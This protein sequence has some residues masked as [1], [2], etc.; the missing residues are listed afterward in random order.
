MVPGDEYPWIA[1]LRRGTAEHCVLALLRRGEHYGFD[2]AR[3]LVGVDG[4]I[5]SEGSIYPL[6]ARLRRNGLVETTWHESA[7]GPPRRYYRITDA[8]ERSLAD[9]TDYWKLF[10][11][12]VDHILDEGSAA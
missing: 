3:T 11:D 2:L 10:R 8:G 6:L 5:A 12:T 4:V 9:F 7:V 1:Q